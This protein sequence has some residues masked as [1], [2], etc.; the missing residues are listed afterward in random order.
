MV[1]SLFVLLFIIALLTQWMSKSIITANYLVNQQRIT[2]EKC[3]NK[4]RPSKKCNGKCHLFK[5]LREQEQKENGNSPVTLP[6]VVKNSTEQPAVAH[7]F[8][9]QLPISGK[10]DEIVFAE[11]NV[12]CTASAVVDIFHPPS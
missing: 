12:R 10:T 9:I 8:A 7:E 3:I 5:Q 11:L 1:R 2:A 6:E 4:K